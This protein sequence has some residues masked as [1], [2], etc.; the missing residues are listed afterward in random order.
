[1]KAVQIVK[2]NELKLIDMEKPVITEKT[3][4]L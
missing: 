3:M 4:Y 1:M 2:P